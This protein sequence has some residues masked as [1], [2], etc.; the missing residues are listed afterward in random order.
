[1]DSLAYDLHQLIMGLLVVLPPLAVAQ[2][3]V[4]RS[5]TA[6]KRMLPPTG[7]PVIIG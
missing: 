5:R 4:H 7:E 3:M 2:V 1:M 6:Y